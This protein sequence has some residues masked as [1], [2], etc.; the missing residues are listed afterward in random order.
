MVSK[1]HRVLIIEDTP[2]RQKILQNLYKDHAWILVHTADRAIRLLEAYVF[3]LISLDFNL[4]GPRSGDEVASFI[5]RSANAKAKVIVHSTNAVGA[6]QI[7]D[8]LPHAVHVPISKIVRDNKTLKGSDRSC[9]KGSISIGHS[10][11][12]DRCQRE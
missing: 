3:D 1:S 10:S 8:I 4:A 7:I 11:L 6:K 9:Q 5:A 12:E 2:D